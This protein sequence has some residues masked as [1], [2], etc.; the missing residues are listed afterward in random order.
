M[1]ICEMWHPYSKLV[2][3]LQA[4]TL[5]KQHG[6]WISESWAKSSQQVVKGQKG[7]A[8]AL[9]DLCGLSEV[10]AKVKHN[11]IMIIT[12]V[13]HNVIMINNTSSTAL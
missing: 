7:L 5:K 12:K 8:V 10:I 9:Q 11:V 6:W 1:S 13:K 3:T 4:A 2:C